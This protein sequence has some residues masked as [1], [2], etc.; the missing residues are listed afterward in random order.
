MESAFLGPLNFTP[1]VF[2]LSPVL[3]LY[4]EFPRFSVLIPKMHAFFHFLPSFQPATLFPFL[5][6]HTL[7]YDILW[8]LI[9][10]PMVQWFNGSKQNTCSE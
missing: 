8:P 1:C 4:F 6:M 3:L 5:F 2:H 9:L 10:V 7:P